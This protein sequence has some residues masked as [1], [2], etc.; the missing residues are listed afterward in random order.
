M[1]SDRHEWAKILEVN[2]YR[3]KLP[4]K[5]AYFNRP[6]PLHE[7]FD[8]LI[9]DK[10]EVKI[11]DLGCGLLATTGSY[12]PGV[13]V[14]LFPS[15]FLANQ[16]NQVFIDAGIE[17]LIP[18]ERQD[19]ESLTYED[20][21]FDIVNC[22]NALDHTINPD[23]ALREMIRVCRPGGW[24]YLRHMPANGRRSKYSGL[25]QW[26]IDME[27]NGD[28]LF[29]NPERKFL[30]SD[31]DSGFTS[32]VKQEKLPYPEPPFIVSLY[33]KWDQKG[34]WESLAKSNPRYYINTDYG[35]GITED[36]FR[37]SG[38]R[39]TKRHITNDKLIKPG[40]VFVEIGCGS[41]RMT[42]FIAQSFR[43]VWGLDI[44]GEMI[45]IAKE[46]LGDFKNIRFIETEGSTIP[47]QSNKADV[48]F[49]YLV[50]QHMKDKVMVEKNFNEA[51]RVLKPNGIFKVRIRT[52][53]LDNLE[54]WWAGVYYTEETAYEMYNRI[55]FSLIKL[56]HVEHYGLWL[57]L[58]K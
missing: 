54:R 58:T 32:S 47:L 2:F 13:K 35:K 15:D 27:A 41:G 33:R 3:K 11:A 37:L 10:K 36:K 12:K 16:Y 45:R 28:C 49:S 51:Y 25:H 8:P 7:Y 53:K 18:I 19:M 5:A 31:I 21:Y 4:E 57:W 9:G 48:I 30:L 42:E 24:V 17:R 6:L 34:L 29:W 14:S 56:Q 52:D 39:D 43:E 22:V 26:N 23:K 20:N 46:R 1:K 50:F 55:G 40:G 44:S 38:E